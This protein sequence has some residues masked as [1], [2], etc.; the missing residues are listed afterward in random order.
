[1]QHLRIQHDM[2][3]E[4]KFGVLYVDRSY[5]AFVYDGL[6]MTM[7]A[8]PVIKI[9][10][11]PKSLPPSHLWHYDEVDRVIVHLGPAAVRFARR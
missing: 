9:G 11:R 6:C 7:N 8:L 3:I 10:K 2:A 1:M 5:G 4:H